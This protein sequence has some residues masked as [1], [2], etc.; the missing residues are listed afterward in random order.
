MAAEAVEAEAATTKQKK[1]EQ[2]CAKHAEML[3]RQNYNEREEWWAA[4]SA[5][6]DQRITALEAIGV[7]QSTAMMEIFGIQKEMNK[8][9]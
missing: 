7:L 1:W 8:A 2:Q 4:W 5:G 3:A 9:P 6:C